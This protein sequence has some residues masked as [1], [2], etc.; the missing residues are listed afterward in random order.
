MFFK[1]SILGAICNSQGS[2]DLVQ[3]KLEAHK[4]IMETLD[5]TNCGFKFLVL[6]FLFIKISNMLHSQVEQIYFKN[7][8]LWRFLP[9]EDEITHTLGQGW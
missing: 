2:Q 1:R 3:W 7:L 6:V 4:I 5:V 8:L 9:L